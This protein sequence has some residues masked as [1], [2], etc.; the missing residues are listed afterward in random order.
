MKLYNA[1]MK[2]YRLYVIER[3]VMF[4]FELY[5]AYAMVMPPKKGTN[6]IVGYIFCAG[7]LI[8]AIYSGV[9]IVFFV[10]DLFEGVQKEQ[11]L[12]VG[13]NA[14]PH[15][16]AEIKYAQKTLRAFDDD[17]WL[18]GKFIFARNGDRR[19]RITLR[20]TMLTGTLK[21][22]E[23]T[24]TTVEVSYFRRSKLIKKVV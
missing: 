4:V 9:K 15:A 7:F 13:L 6:R 12:Y 24:G 20:G 23:K 11:M 1:I 21:E 2:T 5:V 19:N 3:L 8:A 18:Y 14:S 10:L 22:Y 16:F 17:W